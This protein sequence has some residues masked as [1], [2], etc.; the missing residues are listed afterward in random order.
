MLKILDWKSLSIAGKAKALARPQVV[1]T[2]QTVNLV[3]QIITSVRKRGDR[4]LRDYAQR[5]DKTK[6]AQL[7]I[8][9][10]ALRQAGRGLPAALKRAIR[11]AKDNIEAFHRA[12][13]P[14]SFG[15]TTM[16]G[17]RCRLEWRPIERV[18]LYIP[19]GTA[20]LFSSLLMQAIPARLAGCRKIILCTPMKE[21][22]IHPAILYTAHL[23]GINEV[24]G[25]GGAQAIAAMAYGTESIPKV[26]KICGPGNAYVTCAKQLVAQDPAG[27]AIDMPAG[28]SEVMVIADNS[29]NPAWVAADLLAQAE[30]DTAAQA[31]LVTTS[32]S[33]ASQVNLELAKQ[34]STLPRRAIAQAALRASRILLVPNLVVGV[35]IANAYAPEHLIIQTQH[36]AKL[37]RDVCTAG[38]VFVGAFTP[39]SAGD[40]ASGTN[41]V[42]PTY[43]YA[44]AYSGLSVYSFLRTMTVQDITSSGLAALGPSIVAMAEAEGLHA[45]AHAVTLRLEDRT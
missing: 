29:A 7:R 35:D 20:P 5:F 33:L 38:S 39:E 6:I 1:D 19:G 3:G 25:I 26:D 21:D 34:L 16:P 15:L 42:L 22:L 10:D 8:P 18:G 13:L 17:V 37:V 41:H 12:E 28:P 24:Y 36:A 30:H 32:A 14:Q 40:Y 31:L 23:C 9:P 11:Q 27:A 2:L 43:G 4:A 45:H 44:R